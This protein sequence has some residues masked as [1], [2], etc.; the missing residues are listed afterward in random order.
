M[1][2]LTGILNKETI[3]PAQQ[4]WWG[5]IRGASVAYD[6]LLG[7]C[8]IAFVFIRYNSIPPLMAMKYHVRKKTY[9]YKCLTRNVFGKE[10]SKHVNSDNTTLWPQLT[11]YLSGVHSFS[12]LISN[13]NHLNTNA[14]AM[15]LALLIVVPSICVTTHVATGNDFLGSWATVTAELGSKSRGKFRTSEY[16]WPGGMYMY[17][18]GTKVFSY[19]IE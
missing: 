10:E 1:N 19:E 2:I 11:I 16:V 7:V 5:L 8:S 18:T 3:N 15:A 4:S 6:R 12:I 14:P 13:K 17:G 9:Q